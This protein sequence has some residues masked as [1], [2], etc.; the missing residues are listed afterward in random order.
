FK[1]SVDRPTGGESP[2]LRFKGVLAN[3]VAEER[4]GNDQSKYMV[5][6]FNFAEVEVID[7]EEPYPF[8]IA[9][10]RIGYKP[11]KDSRGG[12]KWDA[13]AGSLRKLSPENPDLD[14]LVGHKQEWARLPFKIRSPLTDEEG[15]PQLDGNSRPIWGDL[16]V[17]CW[18]VVACEGLGSAEEKD[19]DF[20][21][22]LVGLA[23]GKTEPKFYEAALTD[24]KVM[25]R[26]NIVEAIT[27]RK[28]LSTLTE[29]NLLTQDAE[30]IL[31]KASDQGPGAEAPST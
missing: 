1:P 13:F 10:I 4:T 15:Q 6:L 11:P 20:N 28:L 23:D 14:V 2:L 8:P 26:P 18:K 12:T 29:M 25:A 5:I 21:A 27:G 24:S 17:L 22:Y 19:A 9:I 30:G 3:Y 16:D 31:H 7:S